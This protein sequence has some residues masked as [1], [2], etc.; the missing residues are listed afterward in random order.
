MKE[1]CIIGDIDNSFFNFEIKH[2]KLLHVKT[3]AKWGLLLN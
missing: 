3:S 1:G 2:R